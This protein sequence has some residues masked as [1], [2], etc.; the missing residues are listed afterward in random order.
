MTNTLR[1][2]QEEFIDDLNKLLEEHGATIYASGDGSLDLFFGDGV[3]S[4]V[5]LGRSISESYA[6]IKL[7][8]I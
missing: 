7:E 4:K 1:A 2:K 8:E 5:S 3:N 6:N